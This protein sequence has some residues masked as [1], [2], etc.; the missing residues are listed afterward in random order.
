MP[1]ENKAPDLD[2]PEVS[3]KSDSRKKKKHKDKDKED[4]LDIKV[5]TRCRIVRTS[6]NLQVELVSKQ[7]FYWP[8]F[9]ISQWS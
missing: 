1:K 5:D 2:D 9:Y 4:T 7:T 8:L 3:S 6:Y